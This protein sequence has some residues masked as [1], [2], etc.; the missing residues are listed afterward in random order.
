MWLI[1]VGNFLLLCSKNCLQCARWTYNLFNASHVVWIVY[2]FCGLQLCDSAC[3]TATHVVELLTYDVVYF[4]ETT[5]LYMLEI[6][7]GVCFPGVYLT[8][9][10]EAW[11]TT[12]SRMRVQT[13]VKTVW[14]DSL[15]MRDDITAE[16]VVKF[17][18]QS[19]TVSR[20][21]CCCHFLFLFFVVVFFIM[22]LQANHNSYVA[23]VQTCVGVSILYHLVCASAETSRDRG[24]VTNMNLFWRLLSA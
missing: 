11:L 12:G 17:S 5:V 1:R 21:S 2:L 14:C 15:F 13:P 20:C 8:S 4:A 9:R 19:K 6:H 18:V 23:L 10:G 22:P 3:C 16:I 7:E 24:S